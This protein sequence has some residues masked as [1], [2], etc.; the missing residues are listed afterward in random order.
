MTFGA[1]PLKLFINVDV[2]GGEAYTAKLARGILHVLKRE[3]LI[4]SAFLAPGSS[5]DTVAR[6]LPFMPLG[7]PPAMLRPGA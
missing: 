5:L 7:T 6:R 4:A 3:S 1:A 2:F